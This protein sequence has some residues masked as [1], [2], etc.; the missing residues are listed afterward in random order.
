MPTEVYSVRMIYIQTFAIILLFKKL[1]VP[2]A[3]VGMFPT[4]AK[5][6]KKKYLQETIRIFFCTDAQIPLS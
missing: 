4:H 3:S 6:L 1:I 2:I 5:Y